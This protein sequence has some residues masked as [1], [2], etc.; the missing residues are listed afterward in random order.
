[1]SRHVLHV[2][3]DFDFELLSIISPLRDYRLCHQINRHLQLDFVRMNDLE[4]TNEKKR[5]QA[6]FPVFTYEDEIN[7]LQYFLIGNKCAGFHLIP[8]MK[9][10]DYFLMMRG[11]AAGMVKADI[12]SRL[13]KLSDIQTLFEVEPKNLKSKNNLIFE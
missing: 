2:D 10:V 13:K 1:M 3:F 7:F 6:Q 5:I 9:E 12:M 4:I 8:E 11:D